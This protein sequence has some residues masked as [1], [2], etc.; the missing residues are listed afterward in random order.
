VE[1]TIRKHQNAVRRYVAYK[2]RQWHV[3][4]WDLLE[5]MQAVGLEGLWLAIRDY[6]RTHPGSGF[7]V[8][9]QMKF[10]WYR[11]FW[12]IAAWLRKARTRRERYKT[13]GDEYLDI[14]LER[15]AFEGPRPGR[16]GVL[17]ELATKELEWFLRLANTPRR[18]MALRLYFDEGVQGG[19][20]AARLGASRSA[21]HALV[22]TGLDDIRRALEIKE[23]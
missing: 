13:Y 14:Q 15:R 20:L 19:Q 3:E 18:R 21:A 6:N 1:A 11:V 4:G 17:E 10:I 8:G 23:E 12:K 9:G 5:D 7:E 22:K 2:A 16:V